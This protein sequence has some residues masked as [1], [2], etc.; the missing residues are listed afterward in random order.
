MATFDELGPSAAPI[1]PLREGRHR[2][3]TW[4]ISHDGRYG[5][6]LKFWPY[7]K[8]AEGNKAPDQKESKDIARC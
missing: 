6:V 4:G 8:G 3:F 1:R 2:W 7:E 5:E